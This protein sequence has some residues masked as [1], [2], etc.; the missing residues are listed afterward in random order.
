MKY[1]RKR[2]TNTYMWN[3]K[4]DTSELVYRTE[5]DSQT[6]SRLEVASGEKGLGRDSLGLWD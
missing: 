3:L 4:Y 2:K 5:T 6:E 1:I